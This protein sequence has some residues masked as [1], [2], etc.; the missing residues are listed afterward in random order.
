[1]KKCNYCGRENADDA[2]CCS[3]CFQDERFE[4]DA[5]NQTKSSAKT[6]HTKAIWISLGCVIFT[7][8]LLFFWGRASGVSGVSG[9]FGVIVILACL[10]AIKLVL[11][12]AAITFVVQGFRVHWGWGL[13][14]LLIPGAIIPFSFLYPKKSKVPLIL[15]GIALVLLLIFLICGRH[16]G[17]GGNPFVASERK[18]VA[19]NQVVGYASANAGNP[20]NIIF[21]ITEIWKGSEEASRLGIT[22]GMQF[23]EDGHVPAGRLP[24]GAIFLFSL[25]TNL[26]AEEEMIYVR[27]GR[28]ENMTVKEFKAKLGL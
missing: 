17:K 10:S 18:E 6:W 2:T 24:D 25:N 16:S 22:N 3:G 15:I 9:G 1:M 14:N 20:T 5:P 4:S 8:I 19:T 28:V 23:T 26:T 21:T 11:F 12:A 13:A 27:S 7:I